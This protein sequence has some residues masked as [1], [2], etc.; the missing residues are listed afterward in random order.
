MASYCS[1]LETTDY[2]TTK[3]LRTMLTTECSLPFYPKGLILLLSN[4]H[5]ACMGIWIV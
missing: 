2:P 1:S 5:Y 4:P 3:F